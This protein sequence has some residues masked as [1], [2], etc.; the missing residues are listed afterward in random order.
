MVRLSYLPSQ[1]SDCSSAR[2]HNS[3]LPSS[4]SGCAVSL[5][6]IV[7]FA[8]KRARG[9]VVT[10]LE[11]GSSCRWNS[12]LP[13]VRPRFVRAHGY[14]V[15]LIRS[16]IIDSDTV[17]RAKTGKKSRKKRRRKR[18]GGGERRRIIKDKRKRGTLGK[19][20][21]WNFKRA[22]FKPPFIHVTLLLHRSFLKTTFLH[23]P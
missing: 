19:L 8:W 12:I 2:R 5:T 10:R 3:Y 1:Q 20:G 18:K 7:L 17:S 11:Q 22:R 4:I 13:R 16:A 9:F 23:S 6:S 14:S 21:W 15:E